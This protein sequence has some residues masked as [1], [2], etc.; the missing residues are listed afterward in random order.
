MAGYGTVCT[1]AEILGETD[2]AGLLQQTLDEEKEAD[3]TSL[4]WQK[5]L[6]CR[7]KPLK[8]RSSHSKC[9]TPQCE[10][11]LRLRRLVSL[12]PSLPVTKVTS[13]TTFVERTS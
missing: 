8:L 1:Y 11:F 9:L 4:T 12:G 5:P 7:R 2:F 3:E 6:T 10:A 13:P